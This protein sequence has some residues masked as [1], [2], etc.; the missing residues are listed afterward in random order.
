MTKFILTMFMLT[1]FISVAVASD[2][3]LIIVMNAENAHNKGDYKKSQ[4]LF[5]KACYDLNSPI[6]CLNFGMIYVTNDGVKKDYFKAYELFKRACNMND[7]N[8]TDDSAEAKAL[9]CNNV[10]NMYLNGDGVKQNSSTSK[11]YFGKACDLKNQNACT[12]YSRLNKKT[13]TPK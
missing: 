6:G 13:D 8:N 3:P 10:G 2:S 7:T 4:E 1:H 11:E 5:T 9:A 12:S